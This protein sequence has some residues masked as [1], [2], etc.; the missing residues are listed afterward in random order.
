V[1]Q[2]SKIDL[3]EN[4]VRTINNLLKQLTD[5]AR[6][7]TREELDELKQQKG[8]YIFVAFDDHD[9]IIGMGSIKIDRTRML[10]QNY[11]KGFIGYVVV[12]ESARDHGVDQILM[13]NMITLALT[14]NAKQ[15]NLTSS[16]NNPS[17][18]VAIRMYQRFGFER[19]GEIG[20]NDHFRLEL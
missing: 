11:V 13:E 3:T 20:A 15:V 5:F 7:Y 2:L 9:R 4:D 18:A 6:E 10:T 8:L 17:R 1:L 19:I 14:H 16:P 12:D